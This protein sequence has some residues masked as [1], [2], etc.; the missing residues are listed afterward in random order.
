M[1]TLPSQAI[2]IH[3]LPSLRKNLPATTLLFAS[4][5]RPLQHPLPSRATKTSTPICGS[6]VALLSQ[7]AYSTTTALQQLDGSCVSSATVPL[8]VSLRYCLVDS[9]PLT[10]ISVI[11]A[12]SAQ[13]TT[14]DDFASRVWPLGTI[15]CKPAWSPPPLAPVASIPSLLAPD[16]M[17]WPPAW[18][19]A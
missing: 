4:A 7:A 14:P 5:S 9:M 1:F 13:P 10:L 19:Y 8:R 11:P 16:R 15:L 6:S 2:S 18:A 12:R 17:L 3:L